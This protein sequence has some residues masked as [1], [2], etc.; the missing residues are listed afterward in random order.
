MTAAGRSSRRR[1]LDDVER[2]GT[3]LTEAKEA[4]VEGVFNWPSSDAPGKSWP[5]NL[6]MG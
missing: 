6:F 3:D 5:V 4:V 2:A 1:N